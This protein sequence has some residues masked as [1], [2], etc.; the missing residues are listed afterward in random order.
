MDGYQR[1]HWIAARGD[2]VNTFSRW[3]RIHSYLLKAGVRKLWKRRYNKRQ[4]RMWRRLITE[5]G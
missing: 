1:R 2:E 3:R 5:T 4:R